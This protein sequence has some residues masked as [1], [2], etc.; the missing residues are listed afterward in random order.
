MGKVLD[1]LRNLTSGENSPKPTIT[2][3]ER[4]HQ[5]EP[6]EFYDDGLPN[7]QQPLQNPVNPNPVVPVNQGANANAP[8]QQFVQGVPAGTYQKPFDTPKKPIEF[9]RK[10]VYIPPRNIKLT[11]ILLENTD[12]VKE[13]QEVVKKIVINSITGG[14][15][16]I[17]NYGESINLTQMEDDKLFSELQLFTENADGKSCLYD[18]LSVLN[19][20]VNRS[21]QSQVH[22]DFASSIIRSIDII[23]IG[24]CIDNCAKINKL[25]AFKS[26][27]K[28]ID[29]TNVTTKYFC[30][31]DTCFV[32]AAEIGFRSIG[33]IRRNF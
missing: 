10:P 3:P 11:V 12:V 17:I 2:I 27:Q 4:S 13:E 1:F 21:Y 33:A 24:R 16:I 20:I 5:Y 25:D 9:P 30:I 26:F 28:V 22:Y 19:K 18:A 31:D 29:K 8:S 32:D 7:Y 15:Y 14:K 6:I 23:G